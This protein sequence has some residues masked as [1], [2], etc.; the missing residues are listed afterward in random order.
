MRKN[1]FCGARETRKANKERERNGAIL[2]SCASCNKAQEHLL[3]VVLL[4]FVVV[5]SLGKSLGTRQSSCARPR[6][7]RCM[8]KR[9]N[10]VVV[11]AIVVFVV[12]IETKHE[13][14]SLCLRETKLLNKPN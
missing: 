13:T 7:L 10:V 14:N 6:E 2:S 5:A 8:S 4:L 11:V 9:F 12:V 3:K 1:S